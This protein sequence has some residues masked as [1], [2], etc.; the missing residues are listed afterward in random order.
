MKNHLALIRV[1]YGWIQSASLRSM[2]V[3]CTSFAVVKDASAKPI[4]EAPVSVPSKD[5]KILTETEALDPS[6][7]FTT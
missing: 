5:E 4:L 3:D 2:V 7:V 1:E 6:Y